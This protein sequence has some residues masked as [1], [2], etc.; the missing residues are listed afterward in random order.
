MKGLYIEYNINSIKILYIRIV[1]YKIVRPQKFI[2]HYVKI[3]IKNQNIRF[4]INE[5]SLMTDLNKMTINS[6][7]L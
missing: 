4:Y 5:T 1:T 6:A 2:W 3:S 7:R